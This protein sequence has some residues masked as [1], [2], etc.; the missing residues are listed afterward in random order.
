M[1]F[2][3]TKMGKHFFE[4]QVPKLT[5]SL[6]QIAETLSHMEKIRISAEADPEI[7]SDIY[8]GNY[9]PAGFCRSGRETELSRRVMETEECLQNYLPPEAFEAFDAYQSAVIERDLDT[10]KHSFCSGFQLAVQLILAGA[11]IS[12]KQKEA[13]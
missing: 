4:Y 9:E 11:G 10:A 12:E 13:A 1:N 2:Y 7:L 3:E 6:G 8:F 5:D